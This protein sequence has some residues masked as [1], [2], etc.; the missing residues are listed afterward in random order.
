MQ[1]DLWRSFG[2]DFP[3][4]GITRSQ[5]PTRNLYKIVEEDGKRKVRVEFD[6]ENIKPENIEVKTMGNHVEI[7]AKLEEKSNYH[8][9][10]QEYSRRIGLPDGVNPQEMTCKFED[11][12][13]TLEAPYSPPAVESG[14]NSKKIEVQHDEAAKS[15]PPEIPIK[16]Q[17]RQ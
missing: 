11:G 1:T 8:T 15:S 10:Y 6:V 7:R 14:E 4:M 9:L 17:Q 2:Q 13:V 3:S 12:V 16:H 5:D